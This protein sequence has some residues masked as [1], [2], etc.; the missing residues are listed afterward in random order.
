M[1][2]RSSANSPTASTNIFF[3]RFVLNFIN[4]N[5]SEKTFIYHSIM[6]HTLRTQLLK[7]AG[8]F[9]VNVGILLNL[10]IK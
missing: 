9:G 8:L 1:R 3:L 5:N 6:M 10:S 2:L 7:F 4:H